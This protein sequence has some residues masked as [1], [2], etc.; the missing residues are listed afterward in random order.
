MS[1]H[2][3]LAP[4][5]TSLALVGGALAQPSTPPLQV[6]VERGDSLFALASRYDT[7]VDALVQTNG[8]ATTTLQIGQVL[9]LPSVA[10]GRTAF[11]RVAAEPAETLET[12]AARYGLS[13]ATVR[14]ANPGVPSGTDLNG[15]QVLI[16]PR[17]GLT[18][19]VAAGETLLALSVSHH[20]SPAALLE[21]NGLTSLGPVEQGRLLLIPGA[22]G[23]RPSTPPPAGGRGRH[24]ELQLALLE[25]A[26]DRVSAYR[27]AEETFVYPVRGRLTSGYGWR[28]ISV[29]GNR[30]HAGVDLAAPQGVPVVAAR[31]GVVEQAGWWGAY[32]NVVILEHGDG[33][34]SRYAHLS[35]IDVQPGDLARQGDPIGLVGSTGASTGPHVH[36]E[37]RFEGRAVDPLPL[38]R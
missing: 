7:T 38:L 30:F 19:T 3:L 17:D 2:R 16:P 4:L 14:A 23:R 37:I 6:V 9:T 24:V 25:R 21:A 32:G 33:S 34:Q 27:P 12:L 5:L 36:F 29:G 8:L 26:S 1:P 28:N 10:P 20:V 18:V 35:R 31:D 22:T 11:L 15:A 13:A